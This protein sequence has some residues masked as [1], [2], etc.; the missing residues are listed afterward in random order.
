MT[1]T[2]R[3]FNFDGVD[4]A[5]EKEFTMPG[6]KGV[7]SI[8]KV[9]FATSK[10]GKDYGEV[11]FDNVVSHFRHRF[12]M[13]EGA[14]SRMQTVYKAATGGQALIGNNVAES[15]I[16]AALTGK[17]VALKVV[18][19]VGNDG[20]G[21]ADLSFGGFAKMPGQLAELEFTPKEKELIQAAKAATANQV[22]ASPDTEAAAPG[23]PG[24]P[25]GAPAATGTSDDF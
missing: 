13:S 22:A 11:T 14:I 15:A 17:Q 5:S 16:I 1:E 6:V 9:E 8:S 20:K 24:A 10:N 21:Y 2:T 18:G 23:A 4:E 25:A 19:R 3:T 7:F 12:Y